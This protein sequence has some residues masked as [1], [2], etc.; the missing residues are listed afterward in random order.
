MKATCLVMA[1][2]KGSR[3][4]HHAEKP[5]IQIAG[6]PMVQYVIEAVQHS[7]GIDRI[8]V[9]TSRHTPE[10]ATTLRSL[11]L[12]VVETSGDDYV[13][14]TKLAVKSLGL[15]KTLVI[16]ADLPLITA[17]IIDEVIRRYEMSGKPAL[18]VAIPRL[19]E[20]TKEGLAFA[21]VNML[22]G[23]RIN[24]KMLDEEVMIVGR[25]E[26]MLNVNTPEDLELVR[27]IIQ[28]SQP[29]SRN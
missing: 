8:F 26:V 6:K 1:G 24:E 22:D 17:N 20:N 9:A 4:R 12:N 3:M 7:R 14:D 5:L 18:A 23:E 25:V 29:E 10:T 21:G 27:A 2:G 11:G 19:S 13:E 15:K 28:S 16:S